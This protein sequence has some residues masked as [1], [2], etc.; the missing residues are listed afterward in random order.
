MGRVLVAVG[1]VIGNEAERILLAKHISERMGYWPGKYSYLWGGELRMGE[2]IE[3]R[4]K[5]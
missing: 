5:L 2:R 3:R 4:S 1:A